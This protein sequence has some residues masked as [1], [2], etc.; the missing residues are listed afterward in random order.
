[1]CVNLCDI[2]IYIYTHYTY[3][4]IVK[5]ENLSVQTYIGGINIS[6]T[7]IQNYM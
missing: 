4:Q 3:C 5:T 1:M 6:Y 7:N 2:Y